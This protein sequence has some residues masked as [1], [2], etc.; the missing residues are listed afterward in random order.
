M[1][2][3]HLL[4]NKL[5]IYSVC[6]L[7][8]YVSSIVSVI[9]SAVGNT[10]DEGYIIVDFLVST[11][12]IIDFGFNLIA[13]LWQFDIGTGFYIKCCNKCHNYMK[14]N[15][16]KRVNKERKIELKQIDSN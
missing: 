12:V 7:V 9:I 11:A 3:K 6:A 2:D 5:T 13:I 8:A 16:I 4:I 14:S 10:F 15:C 1:D